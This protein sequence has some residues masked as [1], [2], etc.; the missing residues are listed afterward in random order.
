MLKNAR[1]AGTK[2]PASSGRAGGSAKESDEPVG[3]GGDVTLPGSGFKL[4]IPRHLR[5]LLASRVDK[6]VV[7]GIRPEHFHCKPVET[8]EG[9]SSPVVALKLNVVEPL[10]ND[11]DMYLSTRLNDHV[12]A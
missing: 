10:G 7:L 9:G 3:L 11:M 4:P 8:G 12:V 2:A 5:E 6:H 1:V